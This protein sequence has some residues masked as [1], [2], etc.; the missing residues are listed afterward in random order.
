LNN[1][2]EII[3]NK[4]INDDNFIRKTLP[5]IKLDYF[6]GD[7]NKLTFTLIN[8]YFEKY[9]NRPSSEALLIDL[10]D[11][12][13]NQ[14]VYDQTVDVIKK[15]DQKLD[16]EDDWLIDKTEEFCRDKAIY[17]AIMKSIGI[18]DGEGD[19]SRGSIPNLLQDALA[20]SFDNHIGHDFID[21]AEARYDF[22]HSVQSRIPLSLEWLNKIT[23]GGFPSKT[24]NLIM[25]GTGTGKTLIM[26][27]EAANNLM[28]NK[29]VLYIT[30]EMAEER[31]AERIDANLMNVPL[32]K[33]EDLDKDQYIRKLEKI[34]AGKIGKL[35][36]K[37]YPTSSVGANHFRH[38]LNELKLKKK[39]V[40]DIIYIDYIN[41]CAS[42]RIK[43]GS[44]ANSYTI[45]KA[46]A[47]ELRGLSVEFNVPIVSATQTNRTGFSNS[48]VDLTDTSESFGLPQTVDFMIAAITSDELEEQGQI[49]FKQLKNRYSDISTNKRCLIGIDKSKMKLYDIE[50]YA[51]EDIPVMDNTTFVEENIHRH[52]KT[53]FEEWN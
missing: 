39:F 19:E 49:Q 16:V 1:I 42:S 18:I 27:N 40:P 12:S 33:L 47:E 9:N 21:D 46:I 26:C 52:K 17:N 14:Q 53:V 45:I 11:I 23:R 24:L 30:L 43:A 8:K 36:I 51:Q 10:D 15:L 29:S 28:D 3:L 48:D 31:I 7:H 35:I 44:T 25:G 2:E 20:V 41:I 38:L 34:N 32:D 22:Y 5:Y 50:D 4:L 13:V 6:T 37:E